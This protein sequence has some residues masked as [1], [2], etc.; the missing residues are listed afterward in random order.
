MW[1]KVYQKFVIHL[2]HWLLIFEIFSR[3]YPPSAV[4]A[5]ATGAIAPVDFRNIQLHPSILDMLWKMRKLD[6]FGPN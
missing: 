4:R 5:V 1:K 3:L 6:G 2:V